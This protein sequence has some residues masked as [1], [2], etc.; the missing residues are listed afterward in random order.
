MSQLP[1][2]E[3]LIVIGNT[4]T[5]SLDYRTKTLEMFGDRVR[6]VSI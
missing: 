5:N 1:C 2:V 6:E 3:D 4:V